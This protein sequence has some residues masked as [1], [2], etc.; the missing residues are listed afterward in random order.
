MA[1]KKMNRKC[2][3]IERHEWETGGK[4]QQ[5]QIPLS[6]AN[7]FFGSEVRSRSIVVRFFF[8]VSASSPA[9]EKTITISKKYKNGTRRINRFP[10]IGG[11]PTCFIF[12]EETSNNGVYNVWWVRDKAI[13]A[14]RFNG[15]QQAKSSQYGR[16]R[17]AIIVPAPVR[18]HFT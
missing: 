11:F 16:G 15:W 3:I 12:F 9:F 10:E 1:R 17:L 18:R 4:K 7:K 8:S 6:I 14:T 5:L 13:I 2:L